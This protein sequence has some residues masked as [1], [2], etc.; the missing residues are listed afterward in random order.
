MLCA[1]PGG[2]RNWHDPARRLA[3][4][5]GIARPARLLDDYPSTGRGKRSKE[6]VEGH[7][8][9]GPLDLLGEHVAAPDDD[10][11]LYVPADDDLAVDDE[12]HRIDGAQHAF[13]LAADF[14]P[15]HGAAPDSLADYDSEDTVAAGAT[16]GVIGSVLGRGL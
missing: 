5:L 9:G 3:A 14:V 12:A 6:L 16:G 11:V 15:E 7:V 1:P 13:D 10:H 4:R 8:R 2:P